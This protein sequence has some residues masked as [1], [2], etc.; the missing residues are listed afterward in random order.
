[1][2]EALAIKRPDPTEVET[3]VAPVVRAADALPVVANVQQHEHALTLL[4]DV[5]GAETRIEAV[6]KPSIDA[7]KES[8][9]K[10]EA[11]R[12]EIV[13]LRDQVLAPVLAARGTISAKCKAFELEERR[14][15]EETQ[16]AME[17]SALAAQEQQRELDAAMADTQEEAEDA[18][19][20]PLPEPVVAVVRPEVA[21]VA[22][23][24]SRETWSAEITDKLEFYRGCVERNDMYLAGE[25][26]MVAL[27]SRARNE[28]KDMKIPGVKAVP[29]LSHARR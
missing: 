2:S 27:N 20:A 8:K 7:A 5:M 14:A 4:A 25:P 18:L 21:K 9:R 26:N 22:G 23:V 12:V 15:A 24:T 6:F 17:R 29:T 11:A 1:M 16:K 3:E 19:T 28:K 10:A 13:A